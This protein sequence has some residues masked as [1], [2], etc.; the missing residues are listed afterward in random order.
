M[1]S[2]RIVTH[3]LT[4]LVAITLTG[5]ALG[6]ASTADARVEHPRRERF[7][8]ERDRDTTAFTQYNRAWSQ[9]DGTFWLDGGYLPDAAG[10]DGWALRHVGDPSWRDY[11]VTTM[12]DMTDAPSADNPGAPGADWSMATL[13]LRASTAPRERMYRID[14]WSEGSGY[15]TGRVHIMRLDGGTTTVLADVWDSG[16]VVGE[17][18]VT[19]S[20]RTLPGRDPRAVIDVWVNGQLLATGADPHPLPPGGYGVG[21]IWEANLGV[22]WIAA[23]PR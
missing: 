1:R 9:H 3:V 23:G 12:L 2:H 22:E 18:R 19:A 17:N 7:S 21:A 20:I 10:R 16:A 5:A 13:Y 15:P 11:T 14:V 4:P 8:F 6:V